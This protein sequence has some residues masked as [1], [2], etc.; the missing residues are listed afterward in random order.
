VKNDHPVFCAPNEFPLIPQHTK[1]LRVSI[2]LLHT[3]SEIRVSFHA[4]LS[5]AVSRHWTF[6]LVLFENVY[7]VNKANHHYTKEVEA[8]RYLSIQSIFFF[9]NIFA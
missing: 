2:V 7:C 6:F 9:T 1:T 8:Y 5:L 4:V 3:T